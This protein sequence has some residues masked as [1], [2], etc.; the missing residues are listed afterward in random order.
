MW[1]VAVFSVNVFEQKGKRWS[2]TEQ[3][4][5]YGF[6]FF[7]TFFIWNLAGI[8]FNSFYVLVKKQQKTKT[9]L[10]AIHWVLLWVWQ[11]EQVSWK[12]VRLKLYKLLLSDQ[13]TAALIF[14]RSFSLLFFLLYKHHCVTYSDWPDWYKW[15]VDVCTWLNKNGVLQPIQNGEISQTFCATNTANK[16]K[17]NVSAHR[18]VQSNLKGTW[19]VMPIRICC[20]CRPAISADGFLPREPS[21]VLN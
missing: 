14:I 15:E 17:L 6:Y 10:F 3:T 20:E 2:N 16:Q 18:Q 9:N 13:F 8:W 5:Q 21:D 19:R 12:A 1:L 4:C 7:A 11:V